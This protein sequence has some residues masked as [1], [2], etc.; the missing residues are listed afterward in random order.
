MGEYNMRTNAR[1]ETAAPHVP[2][3]SGKTVEVVLPTHGVVSHVNE[4]TASLTVYRTD[5]HVRFTGQKKSATLTLSAAGTL[6]VGSKCYV[7]FE[8]THDSDQLTLTV[9][10]VGAKAVG[11]G[12]TDTVVAIW[13]GSEWTLVG[14]DVATPEIPA[15]AMTAV[16]IA[17]ETMNEMYRSQAIEPE[18]NFT[19]VTVDCNEERLDYQLAISGRQAPEG[20]RCIINFDGWTV[21]NCLLE[22]RAHGTLQ[23]NPQNHEDVEFVYVDG[24]WEFVHKRLDAASPFVP[25]F[26]GLTN[27][28]PNDLKLSPVNYL[29][30]AELDCSQ[31]Q[32]V[33][34]Q[35]A[36]P[37]MSNGSTVTDGAVVN[38]T[39]RD[40]QPGT[41]FDICNKQF[42][43]ITGVTLMYFGNE[44]REIGTTKQ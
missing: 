11:A 44:W 26:G 16:K 18:K 36:N 13:N 9:A 12:N 25:D 22:L 3:D 15:S 24:N 23:I 35:I 42:S 43:D 1:Y 17:V 39:F 29:T 2:E 28:D 21:P 38:I 34:I 37:V 8:N 41:N 30:V 19:L 33:N 5:T 32:N 14:G 10:N 40:V 27:I 7:S 6:P 4:A 31:L 20:A